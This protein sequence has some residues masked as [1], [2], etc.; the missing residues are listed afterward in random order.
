MSAQPDQIVHQPVRLK[1][2]ATLRAL[3]DGESLE[4]VQLK[5]IVDTTEGNLGAHLT[6]LEGAGYVEVNKDFH[7]RRPR[8]RIRLTTRGRRALE[9]YVSYLRGIVDS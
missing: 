1:V 4:F 8:T 2:L 3:P 6:T 5:G 9:D 7:Q